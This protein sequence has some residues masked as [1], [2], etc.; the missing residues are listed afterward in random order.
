[1]RYTVVTKMI[2]VINS[3]PYGMK[4]LAIVAFHSFHLDKPLALFLV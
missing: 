4:A 1:M 3:H 2:I